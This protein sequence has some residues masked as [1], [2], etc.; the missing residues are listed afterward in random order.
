ML[1]NVLINVSLE[2]I[3]NHYNIVITL[4]DL[5]SWDGGIVDVVDCQFSSLGV[6]YYYIMFRLLMFKTNS[7]TLLSSNL[8]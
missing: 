6:N 5:L 3:N 1:I 2:C 8:N 7:H 4:R